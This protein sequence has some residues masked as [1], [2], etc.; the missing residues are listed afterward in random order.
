MTFFLGINDCFKIPPD[1]PSGNAVYPNEA[2]GAAIGGCIYFW[3]KNRLEA[4][5]VSSRQSLYDGI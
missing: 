4:S 5:T 2:G 1:D 3:L